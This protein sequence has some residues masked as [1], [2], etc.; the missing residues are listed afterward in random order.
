VIRGACIDSSVAVSNTPVNIPTEGL[1]IG[2][3]WLYARDSTGNISEPKAFTLIRIVHVTGVTLDQ[4]SLQLKNGQTA[5]L[6]AT[7]SP[8]DATDPMVSWWSDDDAIATVN[9]YGEVKAHS[10][11]STYIHVSTNDGGFRDSCQVIV[12][13]TGTGVLQSR[14]GRNISIYPNPVRDLLHLHTGTTAIYQVDISS[15][16]G[17]VLQSIHM[18]QTISRINL[19][20]FRKGIYFITIRSKDFVTT[21]KIIKL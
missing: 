10:V 15:V 7:V 11:D 19:S 12:T 16:S 17:K 1:D 14:G 21:R 2:N 3:Y 4:H 8:P 20:S 13:A 9:E 6:I 18:D 5:M